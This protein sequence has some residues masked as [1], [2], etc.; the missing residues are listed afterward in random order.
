[1]GKDYGFT[2]ENTDYEF[3]QMQDSLSVNPFT[4]VICILR[5]KSVIPLRYPLNFTVW[6]F[7]V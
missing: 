7:F 1:M 3:R 4:S 6:N 2:T 5:S